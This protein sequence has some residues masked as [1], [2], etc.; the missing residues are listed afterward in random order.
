VIESAF[1]QAGRVA[2]DSFGQ[3][4]SA[5]SGFSADQLRN[6]K[7][8]IS[9]L[10]EPV[11]TDGEAPRPLVTVKD[12][13]T[14]TMPSWEGLAAIAYL[15]PTYIPAPSLQ[16]CN[17]L[18][19][20]LRQRAELGL[21]KIRHCLNIAGMWRELEPYSAPV[22][23][24]AGMPILG[25]DGQLMVPGQTGVPPTPYHYSTLIQRAKEFIARSFSARRNWRKPPSKSRHRGNRAWKSSTRN[26]LTS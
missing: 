3:S 18:V 17:P 5:A 15:G 21:Y 16:F 19:R 10:R 20:V 9:W 26:V 25:T 4:L 22:Q 1:V 11:S 12:L 24:D 2:A 8:E 13:V 7:T 14:A 6:T 23:A